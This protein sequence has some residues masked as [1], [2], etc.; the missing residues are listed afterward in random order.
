M[1]KDM[2]TKCLQAQLYERES[3]EIKNF[4]TKGHGVISK[5][6]NISRISDI[7]LICFTNRIFQIQSGFKIFFI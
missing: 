1:K 7:R 3:F 6:S 5:D 4:E 2:T